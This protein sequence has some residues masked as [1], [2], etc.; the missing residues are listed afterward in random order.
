MVVWADEATRYYGTISAR[1][2]AQAGNGSQVEVSGK[3]YLDFNGAVDAAAPMGKNGTLLLD[4]T[5]IFISDGGDSY[6][7]P[8]L[9]DDPSGGDTTIDA[10]SLMYTSADV[11]LQATNNITV[12]DNLT[13]GSPSSPTAAYSLTMQA[14]NSIIL[15][16]GIIT[17]GGAV[18]LSANDNTGGYA[19]GTGTVTGNSSG[20]ISTDGGDI[21]I[22]GTE[23]TLNGSVD[24]GD[25]SLTV[26]SVNGITLS[27]VGYVSSLTATNT[28]SGDISIDL[29]V[30]HDTLFNDITN[31][32]GDVSITADYDIILGGTIDTPNGDVS[33]VSGQGIIDSHNGGPD[34]IAKHLEMVA[35]NGIGSDDP[36]ETKVSTLSAANYSSGDIRIVNTGGL[37]IDR[38]HNEAVAGNVTLENYGAIHT[39]NG[40][41]GALLHAAGDFTLTAHSPLIIGT[42]GITTA[43]GSINLTAGGWGWGNTLLIFGDLTAGGDINLTAGDF[44]Y[45]PGGIV[46]APDFGIFWGGSV[47]LNA[48][49]GNGDICYTLNPG[50]IN[51]LGDMTNTVQGSFA[52]V[53]AGA[54]SG[55][56]TGGLTGGP[57]EEDNNQ[58]KDQRIEETNGGPESEKTPVHV[59]CN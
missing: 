7:D 2:G 27:N 10:Y 54:D 34:I 41:T 36:L 58:K 45:W 9:F 13:V 3:Q 46:L 53:L 56:P 57:A 26:T 43:G 12:N 35:Q 40:A 14:G 4:P 20:S 32:N 1:G 22:S 6:T 37:Q 55:Y 5:N 30:E 44:I 38:L 23:V 25:G 29:Q 52:G 21:T 39:A 15:N 19:S 49:G 47:T 59:Y 16:A 8:I 11:T 48:N 28:G 18:T 33:L 51:P 42:A 50:F 17:T 31:A 24:A